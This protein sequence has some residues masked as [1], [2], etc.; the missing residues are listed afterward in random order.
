MVHFQNYLAKWRTTHYIQYI[1]F[2]HPH[3]RHDSL[4]QNCHHY[5]CHPEMRQ[6]YQFN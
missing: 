5:H 4:S 1:P 6:N 2:L 3:P